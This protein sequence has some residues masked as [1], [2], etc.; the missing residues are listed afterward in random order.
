ME[1]W[2]S[3]RLDTL[4]RTPIMTR[5]IGSYPQH[6]LYERKAY[7]E[8]EIEQKCPL[9]LD[10]LF[11]IRGEL[12]KRFGGEVKEHNV[13]HNSKMTQARSAATL[14]FRSSSH[15]SH[16]LSSFFFFLAASSPDIILVYYYY[17]MCLTTYL[18]LLPVVII[19]IVSI[20]VS[21][22]EISPEECGGP[23]C[24]LHCTW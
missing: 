8:E 1:E 10:E 17:G 23:C 20:V 14:L 13:H 16:H 7:L 19:K 12:D 11:H 3:K 22:N 21:S 9:Y 4:A 18:L 5:R 24:Y 2:R 6:V 15:Q